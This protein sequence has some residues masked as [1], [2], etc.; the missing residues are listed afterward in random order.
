MIHLL[1]I[2]VAAPTDFS[3]NRHR[4]HRRNAGTA[5]VSGQQAAAGIGAHPESCQLCLRGSSE[6]QRD[7]SKALPFPALGARHRAEVRPLPGP[8]QRGHSRLRLLGSVEAERATAA[9]AQAGGRH[10]SL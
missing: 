9:P 2:S 5:E 1:L 4:V 10:G 8:Q 7:E 6:A 3:G